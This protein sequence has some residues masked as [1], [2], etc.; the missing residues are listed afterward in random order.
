MISSLSHWGLGVSISEAMISHQFSQRGINGF[1]FF[2]L[3]LFQFSIRQPQLARQS[4]EKLIL[5]LLAFGR[6]D[7]KLWTFC[8]RMMDWEGGV[9][10]LTFEMF[11][12]GFTPCHTTQPL[13]FSARS[14]PAGKKCSNFV[15]LGDHTS[16]L[17]LQ[18]PWIFLKQ[19]FVDLK[20]LCFGC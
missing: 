18:L 1:A 7:S 8:R 16:S 12:F 9:A 17:G 13:Y 3:I 6:K 2:P 5:C 11:T 19:S 10:W 14:H 20:V 15:Q 4:Q